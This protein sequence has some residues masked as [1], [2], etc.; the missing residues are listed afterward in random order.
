MGSNESKPEVMT[1]NHTIESD[2]KIGRHEHWIPILVRAQ[3]YT[4]AAAWVAEREA[5]RR[6]VSTG[7]DLSDRIR[8]EVARGNANT[9]SWTL[10]NLVKLATETGRRTDARWACVMDE[11]SERPLTPLST[12][13]VAHLTDMTLNE[14]RDAQRKLHTRQRELHYPGEKDWPLASFW[15]GDVGANDEIYVYATDEQA[16]L[17]KQA[18][19]KGKA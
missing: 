17:W 16:D 6:G 8:A 4:D 18:R 9:P 14:W 1:M 5:Q 10:E 19:G 13:E 7:E 3:D 12:T 15:G 2:H 11:A